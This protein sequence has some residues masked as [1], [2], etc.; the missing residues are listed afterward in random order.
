MQKDALNNV[1]ITDEQVLITPDQ[2]KAE[3]PLS[4][5]QEAQIEHSRQTISDIIAGRACWWYVVLVLFTILKPPL[6]TLVDLKH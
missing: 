5:A 6:S 2:L 3:F 1:H 4:V